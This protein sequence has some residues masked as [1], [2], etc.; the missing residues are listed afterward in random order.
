MW[1]LSLQLRSQT[2]TALLHVGTPPV[3]KQNPFSDVQRDKVLSRGWTSRIFGSGYLPEL[4]RP[5]QCPSRQVSMDSGSKRHFR[6]VPGSLGTTPKAGQWKLLG[7]LSQFPF[8]ALS[9]PSP[10]QRVVPSIHPLPTIW[11]LTLNNIWG[12][13]A[14]ILQSERKKESLLLCK[15]SGG[16]DPGS[17]VGTL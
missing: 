7:G 6:Q 14:A 2:L 8:S 15:A 16:G 3:H 10:A 17:A 11:D 9:W 12:C 4:Q 1:S 5:E 13:W